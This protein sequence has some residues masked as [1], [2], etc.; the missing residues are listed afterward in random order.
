MMLKKID[1]L[2]DL[3]NEMQIASGDIKE[4]YDKLNNRIGA[5]EEKFEQV[6]QH[7]SS[8]DRDNAAAAQNQRLGDMIDIKKVD[9]PAEK[10]ILAEFDRQ[11]KARTLTLP[12]DDFQLKFM[13]RKLNKPICLFGEDILDSRE[14][15]RRI[16]SQ[17]GEDDTVEP[18]KYQKEKSILQRGSPEKKAANITQ[19]S[20]QPVL[21]AKPHVST[22]DTVEPKKSSAR[23]H[24]SILSPELS[25]EEQAANISQKSSEFDINLEPDESL[26]DLANDSDSSENLSK[27][28][29]GKRST[30][31]A[32]KLKRAMQE[33]WL[34]I[35]FNNLVGNEF[36]HFKNSRVISKA[37]SNQTF[38][39]PI[40][41]K[42]SEFSFEEHAAN[43]SQE[44]SESDIDVEP[45]V[46]SVADIVDEGSQDFFNE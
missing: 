10:A 29:L 5:F 16:L 32:I 20:S 25:F 21:T 28:S 22:E 11:R 23:Q 33:N 1:N 15:L 35:D 43:I 3:I 17:L 46:S 6:L 30:A 41:P 18:K 2:S 45:D 8:R 12:T 26:N 14:R 44:S 34:I 24:E 7:H 9:N 27:L 36:F 19:K 37:S 38:V 40:E 4:A 13:L 39:E 42:K 31:E